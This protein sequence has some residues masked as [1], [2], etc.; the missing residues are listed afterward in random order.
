MGLTTSLTAPRFW[1]SPTAWIALVRWREWYDSKLPFFLLAMSYAVLREPFPGLAQAYRMAALFVLLCCYAAFGHIINDYADRE[2]DRQT[3]KRKILANWS[4]P[5]ALLAILIPGAGTVA[6]ALCFDTR[7][8]VVTLAAVAVAALYSLPPVRLKVRGILGWIAAAA[9]QR[10][11]PLA[12]VFQA[13]HGWDAVA[14]ALCVLGSLIGLRFIIVH[15]LR[16]RTNDQR[17]GVATLATEQ[18]PEQL[19]KVLRVLFGLEIGCACVTVAAMAYLEPPFAVAVLGYAVGLMVSVRRGKAI[20]PLVYFV[21]GGFYHV[22]WP[23][24]MAVLLAVRNPLF[25]SVVFVTVALVQRQARLSFRATFLTTP[26]TPSRAAGSLHLT[27]DKADPYPL[28]ARIRGMGPIVKLEWPGAGPTWVVPRHNDALMLFKDPR[29]VRSLRN[30]TMSGG[31][32]TPNREA[33]RG[34]G[35]DLL[36]VDPPDHTR[37]RKLVSTAFTPRMVRR[38]ETRIGQV[39]GDIL[40]R[41]R[42]RGEIELI[43]DYATVVPITIISELLGVPIDDI[44]GFRDFVYSLTVAQLLRQYDSG[45]EAAKSRFT[46]EL[47]AVFAARRQDPRD[48]LVTALVNAGDDGD[49]LSPDELIGM[50]YLLL[51]GG[52]VTTVNLIGNGALALLRHPEQLGLWRRDPELADTAVEELLRFDSP[53]ELS[54]VCYASTD[55]EWGGRHLPAASPVRVL[56]PSVNRDETEFA[57]PDILDITRNP[58]PHL[59]FG[60]GIHHCLGAPLA[61]LEG[62]I[63]LSLLIERLPNLRLAAANQV[64]WLQHPLLRGLEQL[65][66]RF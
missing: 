62:K 12:I 25:L 54:S 16:D 15:Q 39:A 58:C 6:L 65:P 56:I 64:K 18:N 44:S 60:Q 45:L 24:S 33:L 47:E 34:F 27:T 8:V 49:R 17:A 48:D 50:V 37:L 40:D 38:F 41:A 23:I 11:L 14:V 2:A 42:P 36:E 13:L 31:A 61:R 19:L 3:G 55:M 28:Y 53:L 7:T 66:L 20:S 21:F 9:A 26:G 5:A 32:S 57:F 43:A 51:I 63:A 52:F 29:F 4:E 59:S 10:T 22:I 46:R 30:V 1:R 35:R